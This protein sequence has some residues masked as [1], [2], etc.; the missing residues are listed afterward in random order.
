MS[1]N[2]SSYYKC[3]SCNAIYLIS[4]TR[5]A[6]R[7]QSSF[8]AEMATAVLCILLVALAAL[9]SYLLNAH[10]EFYKLCHWT[11]CALPPS[12]STHTR[13]PFSPPLPFASAFALLARVAFHDNSLILRS[14][15]FAFIIARAPYSAAAAATTRRWW[16]HPEAY[17]LVQTAHSLLDLD[18]V[19]AG[20]VSRAGWRTSPRIDSNSSM[21]SHPVRVGLSAG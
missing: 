18:V 16:H 11:P 20:C 19:S 6:E 4:R 14:E 21:L 1:A 8:A 3:D 10:T 15:P 2:P 12:P 5:W 17:W 13:A 7:L 9:P